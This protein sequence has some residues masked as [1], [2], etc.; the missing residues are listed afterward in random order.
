MESQSEDIHETHIGVTF[1]VL[2]AGGNW[3]TGIVIGVEKNIVNIQ[4]SMCGDKCSEWIA[5]SS[6]RLAEF[7]TKTYQPEA[8]AG[9]LGLWHCVEALDTMGKW[10][11]SIVTE[12]RDETVKLH[13]H[14]DLARFDEWVPRDSTR[15]R[16]LHA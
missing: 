5:I 4:Y 13:F 10:R 12:V 9:K 3:T 16:K 1:D 6:K 15:I 2:S 11:E 8:G 7:G 14:G